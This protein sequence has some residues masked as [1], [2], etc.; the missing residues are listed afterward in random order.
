MHDQQPPIS[1]RRIWSRQNTVITI[2]ISFIILSLL[3]HALTIFNLLRI[4]RIVSTQLDVSANQVAQL[5]QQRV[6]YSFPVQQTFPISTTIAISETIDVPINF[7]VPINQTVRIPINTPF[8]SV[9]L[10]I[11]LNLTVPIS[12][13]V[14]VPINRDIPFQTTVPIST[15]VPIQLALGEREAGNVLLQLEEGLRDLRRQLYE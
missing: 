1:T 11:P 15:E 8:G 4:R 3:L 9:P 12:N 6:E 2:L 7:D 5:R 10:D 13:T 14:V